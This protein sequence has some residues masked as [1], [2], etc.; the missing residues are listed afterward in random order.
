MAYDCCYNGRL[1][2]AVRVLAFDV[3]LKRGALSYLAIL[4][5]CGCSTVQS[6]IRER[7]ATFERLPPS[8]QSLVLRGEVREGMSRDA[9]YIAWG[10]PEEVSRGTQ[11]GRS[12]EVWTYYMATQEVIPRYTYVPRVVGRHRILDSIYNPQYIT[13]WQPYR[14]AVFENGRI[15]S[16]QVSTA[17]F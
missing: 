7:H 10:R 15:V 16:W 17:R 14:A 11:R 13:H 2:R 6:R 8:Q 12:F 5:L 4:L 1:T 3:T 9:V